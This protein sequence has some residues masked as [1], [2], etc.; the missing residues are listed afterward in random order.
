MEYVREIRLPP[1]KIIDVGQKILVRPLEGGLSTYYYSN[2]QDFSKESVFI[3]VPSDEKGRPVGFR[4]GEKIVVSIA[5]DGKRYGFESEVK[6]RRTSPFFMLEITKPT[7]IYVVE[8]REYFRVPVFVPYTGK[9]VTRLENPDGKPI[10]Q[11]N[12]K[13]PLKDIIISGYIHNISGG[14]AF[15]TSNRPLE[16]DEHILIKAQLDDNTLLPDV[17]A[18]VVRK[19][20]LDPARKKIGYGVMFVDMEDRLREQIIKFCF[21]RQRELRRAGEL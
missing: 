10:Y 13:L 2:I 3:S 1:E 6:G 8:L 16:I 7:K 17:P 21:K 15:I 12:N 14:G 5:H 19:Q 4:P 11:P 18:R 9:R 20:M